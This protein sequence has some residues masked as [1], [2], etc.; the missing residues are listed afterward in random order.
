MLAVV[1]FV[2]YLKHYLYGKEFLVRTDH[3]SLRW[4]MQ[5]KNPE[6]QFAQWIDILSTYNFRIQHRAGRLHGNAEALS[7]MS[8][9]QCGLQTIESSEP[10]KSVNQVEL[11]PKFAYS[12]NV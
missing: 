1:Y 12:S 9:K 8:C 4:L 5:I 3:S 6:G 10:V 2:I 7:R 11:V